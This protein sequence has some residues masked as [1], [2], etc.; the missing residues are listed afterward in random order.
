MLLNQERALELM[1]HAHVDALVAATAEN[2]VYLSGFEMAWAPISFGGRAFAILPLSPDAPACVIVPDYCL[3]FLAETGT[4]MPEVRTFGSF[5][6]FVR[7]DGILSQSERE[8]SRL[9]RE[10]EPARTPDPVAALINALR[11]FGL[12]KGRLGVDDPR[13]A[14]VLRNETSAEISDAEELFRRVRAVKTQAEIERLRDGARINE[15]GIE[16]ALPG[17][18]E[19]SRWQDVGE[20]WDRRVRELGGKPA[21][22][23]SGGGSRSAGLFPE[24]DYELGRGDP[25]RFECGCTY[26]QYWADTGRTGVVGA[27]PKQLSDY[28]EALALARQEVEGLIRPGARARDL[29]QRSVEV[30]RKMGIPHFEGTAWGHGLGLQIYDLP[31]LTLDSADIL[32]KGMVFALETPYFEVGWGGMQLE[33]TFLVTE[34]GAERLTRLPQQVLDSAAGPE[35]GPSGSGRRSAW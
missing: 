25:I 13:I 17:L 30:I 22:W 12:A 11:E 33:D 1:T 10:T 26:R 3:A 23:F 14:D 4:W 27:P 28:H 34:D 6:I 24:L 18:R 15:A 35:P 29:P 7:A 9:L 19:G 16:A 20:A 32:E 8:F 31:R 21:F 5:G 2:V